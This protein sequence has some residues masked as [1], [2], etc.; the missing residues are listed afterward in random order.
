MRLTSARWLD[1]SPGLHAG[2]SS[3]FCFVWSVAQCFFDPTLCTEFFQSVSSEWIGIE[4]LYYQQCNDFSVGELI[5]DPELDK[6]P[7][8]GAAAKETIWTSIQSRSRSDSLQPPL[9]LSHDPLLEGREANLR[10][11]SQRRKIN[12]TQSRGYLE[13]NFYFIFYYFIFN[14][15]IVVDLQCVNFC[16]TAKCFNC[17]YIY[18]FSYSFLLWFFIG[19]WVQFYVLCSRT[20][21]LSILYIVICICSSQ[22]PNPSFFNLLP[23]W[24]PHVCSLC[25]WVFL[26]HVCLLS[27]SVVSDSLWA[28]AL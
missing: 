7:P 13:V 1:R 2:N 28:R 25:L 19:Y 18:Y 17:T 20:F 9:I 14:N 12:C 23:C 8:L 22:T 15:F 26:F 24:E 11:G 21:C 6:T 10:G 5:T 3:H 4:W 27:H 16:C